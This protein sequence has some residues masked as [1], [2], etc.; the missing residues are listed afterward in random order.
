MRPTKM[1]AEGQNESRACPGKK[2]AAQREGNCSVRERTNARRS[3]ARHSFLP[4]PERR[5][6][7]QEF[8]DDLYVL[9]CCIS[10]SS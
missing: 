1:H 3:Y 6:R 7:E 9:N 10:P 8:L 4:V 2:H 5:L